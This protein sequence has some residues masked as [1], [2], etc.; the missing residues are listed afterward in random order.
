MK[1]MMT[2]GTYHHAFIQLFLHFFPT[3]RIPLIGYPEIFFLLDLRDE[4]REHQYIDHIRTSHTCYLY[5]LLPSDELFVV[6][7]EQHV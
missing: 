4:T 2:I 6:V 1:F 7:R 5:T 3:S